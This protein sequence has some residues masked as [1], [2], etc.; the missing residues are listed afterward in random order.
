RRSG[1]SLQLRAES[2]TTQNFTLN[3]ETLVYNEDGERL[4]LADVSENS[5]V[6]AIHSGGQAYY[7][8]GCDEKLQMESGEGD[9]A[10]LDI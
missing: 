9:L 7:L 4:T 8:E 6:R 3:A 1:T 10:A 2:G 5:R